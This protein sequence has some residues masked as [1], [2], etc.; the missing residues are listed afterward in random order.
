MREEHSDRNVLT[1]GSYVGDGGRAGVTGVAGAVE[2]AEYAGAAG[3]EARSIVLAGDSMSQI[4]LLSMDGSW[5][6]LVMPV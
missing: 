3:V 4:Q 5:G 1:R 2:V 6:C